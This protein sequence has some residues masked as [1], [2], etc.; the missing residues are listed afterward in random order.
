[1][2]NNNQSVTIDLKSENIR[3]IEFFVDTICDQLFIN[4]TY[5]GNIL[6]SVTELFNYLIE[7]NQNDKINITYHSDYKS[8]NITFQ[9]IDNQLIDKFSEK[10]SFEEIMDK[11]ED[12]NLFLIHS[13]VD[14][15]SLLKNNTLSL[16]FDISALHNEI[17]NMRSSLLKKYFSK[18]K[19]DEKIKK[20]N[21]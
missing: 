2:V 14:K 17:Y 5:Y 10:I 9:P 4:D 11:D 3:N 16:E 8:I 12:K 20:E 15:I 6:M 1:M 19:V 7:H 18:Q 13:L 21:D